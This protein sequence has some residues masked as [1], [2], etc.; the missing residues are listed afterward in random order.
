VVNAVRRR[1]FRKYPS[2]LSRISV[3]FTVLFIL[4]IALFGVWMSR[5]RPVMP[6][7]ILVV[8]DP[9]HIV[10][11][12]EEAK[13]LTVLKIPV[14]VHI[15]GAYGV[16]IY[17]LESLWKLGLIS[18]GKRDLLGKSLESTL[19]VPVVYYISLGNEN[20]NIL[21]KNDDTVNSALNYQKWMSAWYDKYTNAGLRNIIWFWWYLSKSDRTKLKVIDISSSSA[22]THELLPDQTSVKKLNHR[23]FDLLLDDLLHIASFRREALSIGVYNT[24]QTAQLGQQA[25][26]LL[27]HVGIHVVSLGNLDEL[28]DDCVIEASEEILRSKTAKY[29]VNLYG[30]HSRQKKLDNAAELI[31]ILGNRYANRYKIPKDTSPE[32]DRRAG[33]IHI[34]SSSSISSSPVALTSGFSTATNSDLASGIKPPD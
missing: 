32:A 23:Q 21:N 17:S 13:Q 10:F 34:F 1:T 7:S 24:T 15:Y 2:L 33:R 27:E 30:C 4:L 20:I 29:I 18:A 12:D 22:L 3:I 25:T 26:R 31:L 19:G 14:D 8:T 11:Y 9:I 5:G 16:G 6:L 28:L